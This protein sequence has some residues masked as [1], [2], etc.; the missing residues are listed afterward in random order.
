AQFVKLPTRHPEHSWHLYQLRVPNRDA[1]A[2][3]LSAAEIGTSVH[4]IPVHRL[5][6]FAKL[7]GRSETESCPVTDRI[8]TEL[9]SLPLYPSLTD[10][11]T[12]MVIDAVSTTFRRLP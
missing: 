12:D 3:D 11:Q 8:A 2:A 5:S 4:F 10:A 9:L 7:L 1:L 6:G